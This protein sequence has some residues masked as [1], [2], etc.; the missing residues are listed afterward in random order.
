MGLNVSTAMNFENR[1]TLKNTA[2]S[3]LNKNNKNSEST[4][5]IIEKTLF[6]NES[7]IQTAN[8]QLNILKAA[9]QISMSKS[10][11]ETVKYL[12]SHR[13]TKKFKR[14]V[15]GEIWDTMQEFENDDKNELYL[16]QIDL[17]SE[18]IFAA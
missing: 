8:S 7:Y 1:D 2:R 16:L 17:N 12:N 13:N 15:F 11:D 9:A 14:H 4:S 3:I 18:N 10:L 5:R 6:S